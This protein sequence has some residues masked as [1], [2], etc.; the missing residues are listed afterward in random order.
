MKL[1]YSMLNQGIVSLFVQGRRRSCQ[2]PRT[3]LPTCLLTTAPTAGTAVP[4]RQPQGQCPELLLA[5]CPGA[6]CH[7]RHSP[8]DCSAAPVGP[9]DVGEDAALTLSLNCKTAPRRDAAGRTARGRKGWGL[10]ELPVLKMILKVHLFY[11]VFWSV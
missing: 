5:E 9:K 6:R 1:I 8:P 4:P 11:A 2:E 10:G 3:N 7:P